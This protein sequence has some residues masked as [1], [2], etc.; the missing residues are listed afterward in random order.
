MKTKT[1][2]RTRTP[3]LVLAAAG[4][5]AACA[6]PESDEGVEPAPTAELAVSGT[7]LAI[8]KAERILDR[9]GDATEAQALLKDALADPQ[10]SDEERVSAVIAQSR[11]HEA[12]DQGEEAITIIERELAAH[13]G[14][15]RFPMDRL[16][17]RLK[18]LL[19]ERDSE[20]AHV[21]KGMKPTPPFARMLC[22]YFPRRADGAV[23]IDIY[24][25]GGDQSVREEVGTFNV[26]DGLR[27]ERVPRH[28]YAQRADD[29]PPAAVRQLPVR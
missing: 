24:T 4:L 21:A 10:L 18:E 19:V 28:A 15:W 16:F 14:E 6:Q 1:T 2:H 7:A 17:D 25:I 23:L 20:P 11:A 26:G 3:I 12:L 5:L 9:G 13:D 29:A 27:A 22:K 8:E